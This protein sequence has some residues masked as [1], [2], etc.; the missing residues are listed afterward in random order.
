[1]NING[2]PR[3][4][5]QKVRL[6]PGIKSSRID[7]KFCWISPK[8]GVFMFLNGDEHIVMK[9]LKCG[10]TPAEV[11]GLIC[12]SNNEK[13]LLRR[14]GLINDLI[15]KAMRWG[16]VIDA[17]SNY[18]GYILKPERFARLHLTGR[19][20][21][22]CI[23]CYADSGPN[24]G[25]DHELSISRWK[26]LINEFSSSGGANLLFTGGE[27]LLRDD[28]TDLF[29]YASEKGLVSRLLT[30]G[31]LVPKYIDVL[32]NTITGAQVSL[33]SPDKKTNDLIR[34]KGTYEKILRAID[35]LIKTPIKVQVGIT[36]MAQNWLAIEKFL[37]NF[38][39]RYE[40]SGLK[41]HI[42]MGVCQH[43]RGCELGNNFNTEQIRFRL[44]D[45][46]NEVNKT[47]VRKVIAETPSCG[48]CE[49]LVVGPDGHIFPC[50]LLDGT[51]G[52]IDDQP[53]T[54]VFTKLKAISRRHQVG[55]MET[56]KTCDIRKAC[57]GTCRV[58]NKKVNGS[59]LK[60]I[61][62][63]NDRE[64]KLRNLAHWATS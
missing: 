59:T 12:K 38:A 30:N 55:Y 45:L 34:G 31:L 63:T 36:A 22:N 16:F 42:G 43:G 56:C 44:L 5:E 50:H 9:H 33:G 2:L 23:H 54:Q 8:K 49:Q 10:H 26:Q 40:G 4:P 28:C 62:N 47:S 60:P 24:I 58:I 15:I 21:L 1:M 48:Y 25:S 6:I 35:L 39:T 51:I 64:Q 13:T 7:D 17:T 37:P 41:F 57:G 53:L 52:H 61:C 3:S 19:C 14:W 32:K 20:Q 18:Y 46:L 27:P 29:M 11:L